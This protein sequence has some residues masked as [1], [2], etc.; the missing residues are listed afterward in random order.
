MAPK[1]SP[2]TKPA[3]AHLT[4]KE[5]AEIDYKI[6]VVRITSTHSTV[7]YL[8]KCIV[9]AVIAWLCYRS[10]EAMSGKITQFES[11]INWSVNLRTSEAFLAFA[12]I[13]SGAGWFRTSRTLKKTRKE[14]GS[15]IARFEADNDPARTSTGLQDDGTSPDGDPT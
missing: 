8:A 1:K 2:Q 4:K 13:V 11:L 3:S 15:R 6:A 7:K 10:I 12:A 5:Q 9:I 14:F